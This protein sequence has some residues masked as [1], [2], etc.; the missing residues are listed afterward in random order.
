MG[1]YI[2]AMCGSYKNNY[3]NNKIVNYNRAEI[4]TKES[5]ISTCDKGKQNQKNGQSHD[6]DLIPGRLKIKHR[7]IQYD[8]LSNFQISNKRKKTIRRTQSIQTR[9]D[10]R[11]S[12]D[13]EQVK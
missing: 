10:T 13:Y 7:T 3:L 4:L 6:D 1:N 5:G 9:R 8:I 11:V 12:R 2:L